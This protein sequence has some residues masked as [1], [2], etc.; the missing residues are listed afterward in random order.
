MNKFEEFLQERHGAQYIG[1]KDCMVDDFDDWLT[2]LSPSEW[3]NYGQWFSDRIVREMLKKQITK[4]QE[5]LHR[6][7]T[8]ETTR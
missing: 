2:Y 8:N 5:K 6:G 1:T 4:H 7:V 3:I